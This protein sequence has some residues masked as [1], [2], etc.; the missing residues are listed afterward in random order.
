MPTYV[1]RCK[2][3]GREREVRLPAERRDTEIVKC[4]GRMK[5]KM[6]AGMVV[7]WAGK[8]HS[9]WSKKQNADGLGSEW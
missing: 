5:R 9:P 8:F 7:L 2:T 3:C 4:H 6:A 1:Y